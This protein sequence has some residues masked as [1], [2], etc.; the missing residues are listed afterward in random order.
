M[1]ARPLSLAALATRAGTLLTGW[2][3]PHTKQTLPS[4]SLSAL[5]GNRHSGWPGSKTLVQRAARMITANTVDLMS[6]HAGVCGQPRAGHR[7]AA[8]AAHGPRLSE[9]WEEGGHF[10]EE[11]GDEV[12]ERRPVVLAAVAQDCPL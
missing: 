1:T 4:D 3:A 8:S 9:G 11:E 2:R 10:L 7:Q 12:G 5:R 6:P